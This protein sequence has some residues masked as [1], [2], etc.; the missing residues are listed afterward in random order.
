MPT[1]R[2]QMTSRRLDVD[3]GEGTSQVS[4]A[5]TRHHIFQN[6]ALSQASITPPPLEML[7]RA[8]VPLVPPHD[9]HDHDLYMRSVV[10]LLTQL[11]P[12]QAQ[13]QGASPFVRVVSVRVW[14]FINIDLPVF[15]GSDPNDD[16]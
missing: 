5:N 16:P 8:D 9:V 14:D 13:C 4:P 2:R 7:R 15:I 10:Q 3:A 1:T 11:V 6:E 12:A